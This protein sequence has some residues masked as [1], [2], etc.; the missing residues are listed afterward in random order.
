M[1]L[2]RMRMLATLLIALVPVTAA[3]ASNLRPATETAAEAEVQTLDRTLRCSTALIGGARS[4]TATAHRGTGRSGGAWDRPAFAKVTTGQTGSVYTLLDNALA[5]ITAGRPEKGSTVI[6]SPNTAASYPVKVWGTVAWNSRLCRASTK[7][8]ALSTKGLS[9]GSAG[10][11]DEGADCD[12]PGHVLVRFRVST[13]P[14]AR[15]SGFRQFQRITAPLSRAELAVGTEAGRPLAYS[16]VLASGKARLLT[17]R[18]C[19][20]S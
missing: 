11:F 5:W 4:I 3:A 17:A 19:T 8:L 1:E 16:E 13:V 12:T 2:L 15:Q 10:V 14:A 9:G 18:G 6:E 7:R 20:P